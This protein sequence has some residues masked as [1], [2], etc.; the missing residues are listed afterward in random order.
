M[1]GV[2]LVSVCVC[3]KTHIPHE[4]SQRVNRVIDAMNALDWR[5]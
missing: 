1:L 4:I 3:D 2:E 5:L